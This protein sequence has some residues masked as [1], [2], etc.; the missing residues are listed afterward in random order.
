[1]DVIVSERLSP[2]DYADTCGTHRRRISAKDIILHGAA[3]EKCDVLWD[4]GTREDGI[5]WLGFMRARK[6]H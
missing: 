2:Y 4:V 3:K 6:P 5:Q 1:M